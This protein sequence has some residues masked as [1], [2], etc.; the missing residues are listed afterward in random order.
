MLTLITGKP[1]N[2]KGV[3]LLDKILSDYKDRR[4][5]I[6]GIDINS[7]C[8]YRVERLVEPEH[9]YKLDDHA[10]VVIDECQKVFPPRTPT[11]KPP[12]KCLQIAEHRHRGFDL[13]FIT[14]D[15]KDIDAYVRRKV[16]RHI[17]I[18][19]SVTNG[20]RAT[21]RTLMND[22]MDVDNRGWKGADKI[23]Y[24]FNKKVYAWYHSS[25]VHTHKFKLPRKLI[26]ALIIIAILIAGY[27]YIASVLLD[28]NKSIIGIDR[29][30]STDDGASPDNRQGGALSVVASDDLVEDWLLVYK[31]RVE[32][33]PWSAPIFDEH[34]RNSSSMPVPSCIASNEDD[35]KCLCHSEQGT[36]MAI[37]LHLCRQIA[38]H[39]YYDY[40]GQLIS[41]TK[42][43]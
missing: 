40:S 37:S 28:K 19:R 43:R 30:S 14:Q 4:I 42:V 41:S 6:W 17:H 36:R 39:G 29:D 33:V 26:Y 7:D 20:E 3:Y 10:V 16:G 9:W 35:N 24:I 23:N 5:F 32:G 13:I 34:S 12:D 31:P 21:V 27:A 38:L 11:S 1:G 15:P 2:G 8:P 25:E 22:V 18:N